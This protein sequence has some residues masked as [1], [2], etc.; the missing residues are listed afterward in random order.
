MGAFDLIFPTYRNKLHY[1]IL[2]F[3]MLIMR[4]ANIVDKHFI[5]KDRY[6]ILL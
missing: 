2:A 1:H 6:S 5:D 3:F 4:Y